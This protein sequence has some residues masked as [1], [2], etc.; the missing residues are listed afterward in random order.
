MSMPSPQPMTSATEIQHTGPP[1]LSAPTVPRHVQEM[2]TGHHDTQPLHLWVICTYDEESF[3]HALT[4]VNQVCKVAELTSYM[5]PLISINPSDRSYLFERPDCEF[6]LVEDGNYKCRLSHE[7]VRMIKHQLYECVK[8]M[9]HKGLKYKIYPHRIFLRKRKLGEPF[10]L[11]LLDP[12]LITDSKLINTKQLDWESR[13][14]R[15]NAHI[16]RVF[17]PLEIQVYEREAN[18][19]ACWAR[20][21][22]KQAKRI[23]KRFDGKIEPEKAGL[24][25]RHAQMKKILKLMK[26]S[27]KLVDQ[28]ADSLS[29]ALTSAKDS[30]IHRDSAYR[31][32]ENAERRLKKAERLGNTAKALINQYGKLN[33]DGGGWLSD[34]D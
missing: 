17:A 5:P 2:K 15:V 13:E 22:K 3:Q 14:A 16:D 18:E 25:E 32:K 7:E 11:L 21:E 4:V 6:F 8:I 28:H 9:Y 27:G 34:S 10:P 1:C 30:Q 29:Q 23:I 12:E 20:R 33:L 26:H 24:P 31:R 19:I